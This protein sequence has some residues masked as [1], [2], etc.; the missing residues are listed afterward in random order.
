MPPQNSAK[1]GADILIEPLSEGDLDQADNIFHLAFGT[2]LGLPDP[3]SFN[4]GVDYIRTRWKADPYAA[5]A[6]KSG[7]KLIGTNFATN[8]GSLGFFGPL[9]IHPD[10]WDHGIG[11]RLMEPIIDRFSSWG[12]TL[13]GLFTFAQSPK[14]VG[15]YQR[16]GFHPRF[17]TAIMSRSV[18]KPTSQQ[19]KLFSEFSGK[20]REEILRDFLSL[21]DEVFPGL[22]VEREILA[23]E[24]QGLGDTIGIWEGS[25]LV[26]FATYHC[27]PG[28]EAGPDTC[29]LKFGAARPG[30]NASNNF[31]KLL[32]ACES[33][34]AHKGLARLV[35]GVNTA[36]TEAY[37]QMLKLGFQT[38]FQGVAMHRP[39]DAGYSKPGCY[40]L[41]DWR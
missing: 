34:A 23:I 1:K 12:T 37:K 3:I 31:S 38:E 16:F 41:D 26:A 28:T 19:S 39:D 33:L 6:A 7:G 4:Q 25:Q 36:R 35:A 18:Q 40:V 20:Q 17:L 27:G 13:A 24:N 2:F 11:K 5:F 29:Y 10:Y 9:T 21:T 14:H 8:W 30:P 32:A 22:S 15:L